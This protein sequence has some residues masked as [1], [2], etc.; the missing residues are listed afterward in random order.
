MHH[1]SP[2]VHPELRPFAERLPKLSVH[3]RNL[4]LWRLLTRLQWASKSPEDLLVH[5]IFIPSRVD[6]TKLRLRI[7]QPKTAAPPLPGLVWLHGGGYVMGKPEMDDSICIQYAR[8]AGLVVVSVD[9]RCAPAHPFPTPL[10]DA[11][12]ALAW[13]HSH[14]EQLG[15]DAERIAIGGESGGGGLAATLAQLALDRREIQPVFQLLIYPMLDDRTA[16]RTDLAE[17]WTMLWSQASN[18]F[19]W[20]SYLTQPCG[21][22][23]VP[24][25][26]VPA[27]RTDLSGLPPAWIGVGTLDLFH[28]E[29]VAYA[30]RL[31]ACGVPCELRVVPGAFHG[32]DVTAPQAQV[33]QEFR[34][35]QIAALRRSLT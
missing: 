7:Y 5:N 26:S 1:P 33:V 18:R 3:A 10:E 34:R 20:E 17:D 19:G 25:Y 24:P 9:Y 15:L 22:A 14:A 29:D 16:L 4:W 6:K 2:E 27:R 23:E 32:F 35:S 13:M 21:A 31:T 11:Y 8:E 12:S 30:H 28:E